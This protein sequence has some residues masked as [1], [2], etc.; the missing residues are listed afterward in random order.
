MS[1][2]KPLASLFLERTS[3]TKDTF[4]DVIE[5][6]QGVWMNQ[7]QNSEADRANYFRRAFGVDANMR[8]HLARLLAEDAARTQKAREAV[9]AV[10]AAAE[11]FERCAQYREDEYISKLFLALKNLR[12]VL[13]GE[14]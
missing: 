5:M 8:H 12:D 3:Q 9:A 11:G 1:D 13:E 10:V 4:L 7:T 6:W 14:K 2:T